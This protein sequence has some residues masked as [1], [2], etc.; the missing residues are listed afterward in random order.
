[1]SLLVGQSPLL[2][3]PN[4]CE[5]SAAQ[6]IKRQVVFEVVFLKT[7]ILGHGVEAARHR[8]IRCHSG[9]RLSKCGGEPG[10]VGLTL[11]RFSAWRRNFAQSCALQRTFQLSTTNCGCT[12]L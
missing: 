7:E 5:R 11:P 8:V 2:H 6:T 3:L 9:G 10:I 4:H 1:M 12:G